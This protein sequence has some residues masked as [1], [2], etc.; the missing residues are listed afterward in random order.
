MDNALVSLTPG[1]AIVIQAQH[2]LSQIKQ[3]I[4]QASDC[5]PT[6]SPSAPSA[7]GYTHHEV[8]RLRTFAAEADTWPARLVSLRRHDKVRKALKVWEGVE[9]ELKLLGIFLI[10]ELLSSLLFY[11]VIKGVVR[12]D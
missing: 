5:I 6:P 11:H 4:N 2:V 7:H 9:K 3:I 8:E 12:V 1:G 10:L